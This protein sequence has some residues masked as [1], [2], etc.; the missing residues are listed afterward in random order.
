[1]INAGRHAEAKNVLIT[2][3]II[4]SEVEL[5]V[6]D[7]GVGFEGHT[8][9]GP[10]EPGHLGLASMRERVELSAAGSR[11]A[12]LERQHGDRP[13]AAAKAL[14]PDGPRPRAD[15]LP[16]ELAAG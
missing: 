7:N 10:N 11:S 14:G 2:V 13:R 15:A 8:P 16:D 9:L 6:S 12:R 5:R 3:R 1:M 4:D